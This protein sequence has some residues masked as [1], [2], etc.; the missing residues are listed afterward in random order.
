MA[1]FTDSPED[2]QRLDW[3]ILRDGGIALYWRQEYLA[4]DVQWLAAQ[5]YDTYEFAC[6]QWT[7][8]DDMYSDVERVLRFPDWWGPEWGHNFDALVDCLRDL[9]IRTDGGAVLVFYKFDVCASGFG[10]VMMHSGCSKAEVLL[11][12]MARACHYL[13]LNG[14]RFIVLVQTENPNIQIGSLGGVSPVWN[15]R[16]W[17]NKNRTTKQ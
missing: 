17:L 7:S 14:K 15:R 6:E 3:Q 5:G 10:A 2:W 16:E 13:L 1:L 8:E 12:V 4:A 9:P 11:D